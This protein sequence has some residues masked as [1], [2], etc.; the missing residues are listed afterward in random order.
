MLVGVAC[1]NAFFSPDCCLFGLGHR[2]G[3]FSR[4]AL[5]YIILYYIK[6][7]QGEVAVLRFCDALGPEGAQFIHLVKPNLSA[8]S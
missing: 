1:A 6:E 4:I 3:R 5:Y 2:C 7:F 8:S